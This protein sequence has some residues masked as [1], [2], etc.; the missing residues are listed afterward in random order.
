MSKT[1]KINSVDGISYPR[2]CLI[3]SE[4]IS[5]NHMGGEPTQTKPKTGVKIEYLERRYH[6]SCHSTKTMVVFDIWWAV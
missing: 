3:I 6:V 1:I 2:Q 5:Q 4:Y